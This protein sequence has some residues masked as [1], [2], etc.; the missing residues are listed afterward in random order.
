M[1]CFNEKCQLNCQDE[2]CNPEID[3]EEDEENCK[4]YESEVT[5]YEEQPLMTYR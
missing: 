1:S 5:P 2:C 3:T 4:D